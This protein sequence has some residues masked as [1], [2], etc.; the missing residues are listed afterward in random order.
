MCSSKAYCHLNLS[1]S[2]NI[3]LHIFLLALLHLWHLNLMSDAVALMTGAKEAP[4]N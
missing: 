4:T 2:Y 3:R 1:H